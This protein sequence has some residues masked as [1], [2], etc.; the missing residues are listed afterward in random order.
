MAAPTQADIDRL[1]EQI[2][3]LN[4]RLTEMDD[5]LKSVDKSASSIS[6]KIG[7]SKNFLVDAVNSVKQINK[8]FLE[9]AKN[10]QAQY[11]KGEELARVSKDT[12]INI[13][14]SVG[15]SEDFTKTFNRATAEAVKFGGTAE[16]VRTIMTEMAS[17][18]GRVRIAS[19][20][21]VGNMIK[22]VKATKLGED[23]VAAMAE[24]MDLMGMSSENFY[25]HINQMTKESQKLGLNS[26]K[27]AQQL[28]NNFQKMSNMS[29]SN[30]VKGMTEMAKLAVKMR[31]EV[32]DMLNMSEKFYEPEAAIEAAANLQ[33]LGG[34]IA[35]AFG[36]PFETMY[37]ARNKPEEL[38]KKVGTMVENMMQF[39][40]VTGEYDIPAEARM[41]LK[42]V[43]AQLDINTDSM[44]DMARQASK[45]K[46]IKMNVSG[47]ITD[48]ETR[49]GLASMAKMKDGKW[50]VDFQG[51]EIG[52]EDIGSDLAQQI[53]AAP[54]DEE[55][56]I[57]DIAYN[58]MTTNQILEQILEEMKTRLVAESNLYEI[59]EDVLKP[60]IEGLSKGV[61]EQVKNMVDALKDTEYGNFREN[62]LEQAERMGLATGD[63]LT[64][65]LTQDFIEEFK[66]IDW[67][68]VF[69]DSFEKFINL[70]T[71]AEGKER[72]G[73][74]NEDFILRSSG[75]ITSFTS[76]DDIIGA[77]KGGPLDKLMDKG[78]PSSSSMNS[79][80]EF[81]NLDIS[82]RIEIVSPDGSTKDI[83]MTDI[84]PKIEN[85]IISKITK[86]FNNGGMPD[87][88]SVPQGSKGFIQTM[89]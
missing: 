26:T 8:D 7:D 82:G 63:A 17:Q 69:K 38:A 25:E 45:I 37:L 76:E 30:G 39:N 22:I 2:D 74:E 9:F 48:E 10:T 88:S 28:N 49:E 42:A 59:T 66:S 18:S 81:G 67:G 4:N 83:D 57:M 5:K 1:Q 54:K 79:K 75:E 86:M 50:V 77:K 61:G 51:K 46:D 24:R 11:Q 3:E 58:S 53:L 23:N 56:A 62:M 20:E 27:V 33:M 55:D 44:I 73:T 15:R 29:F 12:A 16:D 64:K 84:T 85:I 70:K 21:E 6:K 65:V 40:E 41:Q 19:P 32:S 36:D 52:I 71:G 47:N 78:L 80:I 31:V 68:D 60:S 35:K 89:R 43:G 14:L 34:D 87:G 72:T 13:G